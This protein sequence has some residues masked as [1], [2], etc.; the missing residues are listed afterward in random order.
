MLKIKAFQFNMFG[1][2]T[3][4]VWDPVTLDA[5]IIDPG[6]IDKSEESVLDSFIEKNKLNVTQ[7]INTHMHVDHVFGVPHIRSR[8][9]VEL[10]AS[11]ADTFLGRQAPAQ[12]RMFGLSANDVEPVEADVTIGDGDHITVGSEEAVVLAV[13][14]HSPGSVV[15]YFPESKFVITGD[16]LF[17]G[18]IGRTDLVAGN[19]PLLIEGIRNKLLTLP[20][21]TVVYPGHGAPTTIGIEKRS[22]HYLR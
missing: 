18:S 22:N 12:A 20:A 10:K 8:Y 2:N 13:P 19:H 21:D 16:V 15:L 17:Q 3:Y 1:I 7:L 5:A 11:A 4:V 6:M 14:G 9:G